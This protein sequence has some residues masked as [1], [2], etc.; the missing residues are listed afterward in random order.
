MMSLVNP[1]SAPTNEHVCSGACEL[2]GLAGVLTALCP[3]VRADG[4]ASQIKAAHGFHR[5]GVDTGCLSEDGIGLG[6][7]WSRVVVRPAGPP[8]VR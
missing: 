8:E 3:V 7:R 6:E 4:D 1:A 2:E 5:P